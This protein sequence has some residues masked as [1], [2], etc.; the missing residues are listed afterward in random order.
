M[1]ANRKI[2]SKTKTLL[3]ALLATMFL[4]STAMAFNASAPQQ[5]GINSSQIIQNLQW[6][7]H[8]AGVKISD[9]SVHENFKSAKG[10][11]VSPNAVQSCT[12]SGTAGV[13]PLTVTVSV[14]A[15]TCA[16]AAAGVAA[17]LLKAVAT[18]SP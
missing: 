16:E 7:A 18:I 8:V 14:T 5:M 3:I 17:A 12:V 6:Q 11:W 1:T 13:P 10:G 9:V 2:F 15:D 4:S